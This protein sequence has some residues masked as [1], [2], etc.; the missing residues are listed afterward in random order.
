MLYDF[1]CHL[2][3]LKN[4]D[5]MISELNHSNVSVLAVGTTPK[6]YLR[7]VKFCEKNKNIK[8]ACGLHPQLVEQRASEKD[9]LI[10]YISK[11][12]FIGEVGV[13]LRK[14]NLSSQVMQL[15]ILY[16]VLSV[17]SNY[18][19]KVISV[20]SLKSVNFVLDMIEE[21]AVSKR[22]YCVLHWFTGSVTQLYRAITLGCY[23]SINPNMLRTKSGKQL[24]SRIPADRVLLETDIPFTSD[25]K[26]ASEYEDTLQKL[27]DDMLFLRS[28][29][30]SL[31]INNTSEVLFWG[32]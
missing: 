31:E 22:N 8:V 4:M 23:F 11:S 27:L 12:R 6:A 7:E 26:C 1:H 21:T 30:S 13:D 19:K 2:D 25:I 14:E 3:L 17:C 29:F 16:D 5:T 9:L 10:Q 32:K 24:I 20:H 18:E 28:D 15:K